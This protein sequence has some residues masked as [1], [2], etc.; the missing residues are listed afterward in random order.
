MAW[1]VPSALAIEKIVEFSEDHEILSVCCGLGLWECLIQLSSEIKV[2]ATDL[3][4][5]NQPPYIRIIQ[6]DARQAVEQF[7]TNCLFMSWPVYKSSI[8][9]DCLK[10]FQGNKLI[11]IGEDE[12]GCTADDAFFRTLDTK[13]DIEEVIEIPRWFSIS[14]RLYLYNRRGI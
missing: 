11:Y 14:D 4:T 5:A 10:I 3:V 13:W 12:G 7:K 9:D 1:A 8:A 6:M 2:I